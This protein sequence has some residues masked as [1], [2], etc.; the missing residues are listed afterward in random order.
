VNHPVIMRRASLPA[1]IIV[2]L[3][4]ACGDASGPAASG[5]PHHLVLITQPTQVLQGSRFAPEIVVEVRDST[6]TPV[7]GSAVAITLAL[8]ARGGSATLRGTTRLV[9]S[10]GRA[11]FSDVW[12]DQRARGVQL[13][14]S[15]GSL[16][17]VTSDA[18]DVVTPLPVAKLGVGSEHTCAVTTDGTPYC[19]G[20]N[21]AGEVGDSTTI[22]REYPTPVRTSLRFDTVTAGS[23]TSCGVTSAGTAYCWGSNF[24]GRLGD[25]TLVDRWT[26]VPMQG[27][28][29]FTGQVSGGSFHACGLETGG[30]AYCWGDN[31]VGQ[32]GD[33]TRTFSL[34]LVKVAGGLTF[35]RLHTVNFH[36]CGLATGGTAYCWG[37]NGFGQVGDSTQV[38]KL[39]PQ[40]V[41]GGHTFLSIVAGFSHTCAIRIDSKTYCWGHNQV[42]QLGNG[43][44]INQLI[45]VPVFGPHA[46]ASLTAH[47]PFTCGLTA[48]GFAWCWGTS[49]GI[50][51]KAIQQPEPFVALSAGVQHVCGVT[52]TH[53]AY[54]W[55]VNDNGE[56]GDG[57]TTSRN[58]PALVV[59]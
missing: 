21:G 35:E 13:S 39:A 11:A 45:P 33:S 26:P 55:G 40:A 58:L 2:G 30:T 54:C 15:A 48:L 49:Y 10:F 20:R 47:G 29:R 24:A 7:R 52:A 3:C 4:G 17:V 43:T 36:T 18:F 16:P 27:A 23:F 5:P 46:F 50:V 8:V 9:T 57:T 38:E 1:I 41:R 42:G 53:R 59:Y 44:T 22:Q 28:H 51:P 31:N 12:V 37:S 56:L 19:W 32:R 34:A 14:A 6:N 25:S